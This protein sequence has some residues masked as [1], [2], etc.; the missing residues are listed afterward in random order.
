M[1]MIQA[2][3]I[4]LKGIDL[5]EQ[6][7]DSCIKQAKN[8]GIDVKLFNG[9]NG[10]ESQAHFD[11]LNIRPLKKF[12]KGRPGVLG[13]FLSH[14]YLWKECAESN[15]PYLIL[16]HDGWISKPLPADVLSQFEHVL[17][18]DSLNQIGRAHV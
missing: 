7:A 11:K 1:E 10:L 17:K 5:S 13:C 16:E 2:R 14:Y 6:L 9:I 15:Q 4:R 3:I 8:F 12:K 18:L